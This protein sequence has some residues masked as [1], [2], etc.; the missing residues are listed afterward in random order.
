MD[1]L[2]RPFSE[3][4]PGPTV[5]E[6]QRELKQAAQQAAGR[7]RRN[8]CTAGLHLTQSV[9]HISEAPGEAA[10]VTMPHP[11]AVGAVSHAFQLTSLFWLLPT[12]PASDLLTQG[13]SSF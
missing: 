8:P 12:R 13:H 9:P 7:L 3:C 5:A 2:G 6:G 4:A 1:L 11:L 10:L